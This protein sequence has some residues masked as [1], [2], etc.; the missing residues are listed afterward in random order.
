MPSCSFHPAMFETEI[1]KTINNKNSFIV[2]LVTFKMHAIII[3]FRF[4]QNEIICITL[5]QGSTK[6]LISIGWD[7]V[8]CFSIP[9]VFDGT[10]TIP[11]DNSKV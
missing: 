2:L 5:L 1:I 7:I 4:V 10:V 3:I 6:K 9:N 11:L 8:I